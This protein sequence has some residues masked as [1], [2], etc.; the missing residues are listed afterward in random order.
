MSQSGLPSRATSSVHLMQGECATSRPTQCSSTFH[1][2]E[3]HEE[4]QSLRTA[5]T[6]P[7]GPWPI[8]HQSPGVRRWLGPAIHSNVWRRFE[9]WRADDAQGRQIPLQR[10]PRDGSP[11]LWHRSLLADIRGRG[12]GAYM[13]GRGPLSQAG[14]GFPIAWEISDTCVAPLSQSST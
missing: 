5:Y 10:P 2:R 11:N 9:T 14:P 6:P 13:S 8:H 3:F 4:V 7:M 12:A 1:P